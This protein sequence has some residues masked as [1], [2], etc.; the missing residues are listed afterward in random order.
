MVD[1][2][3]SRTGISGAERARWAAKTGATLYTPG[4]FGRLKVDEG[5]VLLGVMGYAGGWKRSGLSGA[6][7]ASLIGDAR[8]ALDREFESATREYGDALV[9][10][11][12]ATNKGVLELAY[13]LANER[14][15]RAMGVTSSQ[16]LRYRLGTMAYLVSV[17]SRFGDES[18]VFVALCDRFVV[19][20]GGKQ[21]H[22]E[23]ELALAQGKP[24]TLITGFGGAADALAK[25]IPRPNLDQVI[26][27]PTTK[28]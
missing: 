7:L 25:T 20:G 14:G 5:L 19:L 9:M 8:R 27:R 11:S 13:T 3:V 26:G 22:D 1:T 6:A 16:A 21:S 2:T 15:I 12:G 28:R 17:G 18:H 10:V 24:V 23:A 4:D